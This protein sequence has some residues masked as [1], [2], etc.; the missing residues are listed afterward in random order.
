MKAIW[1][2]IA[3]YI[4]EVDKIMLFLC[5]FATSF[6]CLAVLSATRYTGSARQFI[7]QV[8]A[9]LL[10]VG[11]AIV[12]S[13]FD[14]EVFLKYWYAFA[15]V[16][17]IPVILTFFIGFGPA[18]TDDKAWLDIGFT[19]FQ[20]SELLKACFIV[21]FSMHL[22]KVKENINKL[23]FL[24]P[25]CAHGMLP[26]LLIHFQGDDG[27]ALVF[28]VMVLCMMWAAGVHRKYF[29]ILFSAIVVAAPLIYFFVMNPDQQ[30]R[31]QTMFDID[32]DLQGS[33]WQQWRGRTALAGG[34]MWGQGFLKGNLTQMG[35]AGVPEGY[36]DFIFTTIGEEW[37]FVGAFVVVALLCLIAYRCIRISKMTNNLSGRLICV[38]F[39]GWL[40]AQI[41]VNLGMC[42]SILPV[43]G[44]TLPFFSAGGTSL[45]CLYIGVGL[46]LSVYMHRNSRTVYLHDLK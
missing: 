46:V 28:A 25:V 40:T 34:G 31:I 12:L 22:T 29:I 23:S 19:T 3:D 42:L 18:G 5:L 16:G 30:A 36:N 15:V 24:V 21:T 43:I 37:G 1:A 2:R 13:L 7:M 26:V 41:T 9:M 35:Q 14:F 32:A 39:F 8:V 17:L 45:S 11:A 10:G 20:P 27:T 6:G 4:R 44:I 33:G 38:G